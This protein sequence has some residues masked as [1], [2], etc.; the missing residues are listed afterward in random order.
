[1]SLQSCKKSNFED[2][3]VQNC[4]NNNNNSCSEYLINPEPS[5]AK[6]SIRDRIESHRSSKI[7]LSKNRKSS[8]LQEQKQAQE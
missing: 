1:M 8:N 2:S 4:S 3:P 5:S 6:K 7:S